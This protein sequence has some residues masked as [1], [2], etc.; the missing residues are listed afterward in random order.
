MKRGPSL[1][2]LFA[3][4]LFSKEIFAQAAGQQSPPPASFSRTEPAQDAKLTL[5]EAW[6]L[7]EQNNPALRAAL[8]G[9]M[10]AEGQVADSRS[11]LWNNPELSYENNRHRIPQ[12]PAA[13]Q[14]YGEWTVGLSQTLEIAGQRRYRSDA[15]LDDLAVMDASVAELRL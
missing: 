15:A 10:A 6:R 1:L 8:A 9:R 3:L 4:A 11:L 13:D 7:A 12:P 5:E 2:W 14:R